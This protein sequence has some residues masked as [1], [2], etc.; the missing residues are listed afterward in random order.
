MIMSPTGKG[1]QAATQASV[2]EAQEGSTESLG[3]ILTNYLDLLRIEDQS[4]RRKAVDFA[5]AVTPATSNTFGRRTTALKA[6]ADA[7]AV[8]GKIFSQ[9]EIC[10]FLTIAANG[11]DTRR[12]SAKETSDSTFQ[13]YVD[14]MENYGKEDDVRKLHYPRIIVDTVSALDRGVDTHGNPVGIYGIERYYHA[15][16]VSATSEDPESS[17]TR[18]IATSKSAA[19][20]SYSKD[21][22]EN[23]VLITGRTEVDI[24]KSLS[25]LPQIDIRKISDLVANYKRLQKYRKILNPLVFKKEAQKDLGKS[26]TDNQLQHA[27]NSIKKAESYIENVLDGKF[28]PH[29]T[30]GI[31]HVKHNLEYGYQ[32]LGLIEPRKRRSN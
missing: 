4:V 1:H 7:C 11:I 14:L 2:P 16:K 29:G 12:K 21:V 8:E 19:V 18:I 30:H 32:L 25:R 15:R 27:S 20:P 13:I 6:I 5:S 28:V 9:S 23:L 17:Y 3:N 10:D 22:L 26:F 31:N 24:E